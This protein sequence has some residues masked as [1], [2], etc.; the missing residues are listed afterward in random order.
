[1]A[2]ARVQGELGSTTGGSGFRSMPAT[3]LGRLAVYLAAAFV[4]LFA[5]NS[6]VFMPMSGSAAP[7]R[8]TV[9]PY[10]GVGM[11]AVGFIAGVVGLLAVLR[12]RE[13]S[14]L[15]WL[16]LLPLASVVFFVLGEFLVPH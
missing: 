14:W 13:R 1:M 15:V 4:V 10:Y 9:L 5:I 11:M 8:Q 7:W 6:F 12:Q 2:D 3:K 16:T